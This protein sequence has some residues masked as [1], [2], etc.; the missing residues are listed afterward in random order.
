M[1]VEEIV[2]KG[3]EPLMAFVAL[4][5]FMPELGD[6]RGCDVEGKAYGAHAIAPRQ[7]PRKA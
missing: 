1:I 5:A 7:R 6:R 4:V 3:A 2:G